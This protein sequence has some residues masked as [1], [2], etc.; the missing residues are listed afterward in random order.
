MLQALRA[1]LAPEGHRG[2]IIA[3]WLSG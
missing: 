3:E 1:A 2:E